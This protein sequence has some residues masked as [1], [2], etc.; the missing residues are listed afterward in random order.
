MELLR[1]VP[2]ERGVTWIPFS[3]GALFRRATG[4][5][6]VLLT[7]AEHLRPVA[8]SVRVPKAWDLVSGVVRGSRHLGICETGSKSYRRLKRIAGKHLSLRCCRL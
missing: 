2:S 5:P 1:E 8:G 4:T 3:P 7:T 6:D